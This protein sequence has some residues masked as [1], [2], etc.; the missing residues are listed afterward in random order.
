MWQSYNS[1]P[2]NNRADDCT[3]RAISKA[4]DQNWEE[5]F[6]GL[7]VKGFE[8]GDMPSANHVWNAYLR[9]KGFT[10]KAVPDSCPDCYTVSQFCKDYPKGRFI[11]ALGEHVVTVIN[12]VLYDSWDSSDEPIFYIWQRREDNV[13]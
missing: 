8:M 13:R 5:T 1:N 7:C 12:G 10:R 4:L 9:D 3:V 11:L 2:Q 6:V